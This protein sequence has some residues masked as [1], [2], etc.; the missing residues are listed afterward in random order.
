L[1]SAPGKNRPFPLTKI[2]PHEEH[3]CP[4]AKKIAGDIIHAEGVR[5][6]VPS[7][8]SQTRKVFSLRE[9]IRV[10]VKTTPPPECSPIGLVRALPA[11][12]NGVARRQSAI[13]LTVVL[14]HF[15]RTKYGHFS[16][17]PKAPIGFDSR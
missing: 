8:A 2:D 12:K 7:S 15:W 13:H 3:D 14:G 11:G 5:F 17:A 1:T 16:R 4:W 9:D 6:A 10:P